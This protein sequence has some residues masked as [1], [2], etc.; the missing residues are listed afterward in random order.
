MK[1]WA[2]APNLFVVLSLASVAVYLAASAAGG[3]LGFPLDDAWI[4][5]T[6]ARN[7]GTLGEFSF[8]PGQL[9]AG[10]TAPL[11]S[12]LIALGYVLRLEPRAWTYALGLVC[13]SLNAWLAYR[14]VQQWWPERRRAARLAGVFV[15]LEWH[16]AWSAV[17]GMETALFAALVLAVFVIPANRAAWLGALVGVSV[18]V[19]PD[20]LTLLPFVLARVWLGRPQGGR[21][22]GSPLRAII[23]CGLGYAAIFV[24]YLLFND[25]L[26]GSFW[27]NTFYAKQAEYA[28]TREAPLLERLGQVGLQPF[29]GAQALLIPGLIGGVVASL[30]QRQWERLIPLAWAA[31]FIGAYLTRLP[32]IYQYGRYVMP[33]IPL[34]V[35]LGVGGLAGLLQLNATHL[36]PRILSRVW[37]AATGALVLTFWGIGAGLYQ[38]DIAIIETEMVATARWINQN[39]PPIALIAAHDIGALGYFGNRRLL[40]MAGLISPEVIPFIRDENRLREWLDASEADYLVTF[41]GWYAGLTSPLTKRF[42]TDGPYSPQ[43]GS[44]NMTVYD[45][46]SA[47]R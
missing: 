40:D 45:W 35:A 42:S 31:A 6:Y 29:I 24:P 25:W 30:R 18:L 46:P 44:E 27:P 11:W 38:R 47:L 28:V 37:L 10:S 8:I 14:L 7:L 15:A 4:H 21:P 2:S 22:Q 13:L 16:L 17:S 39:T 36:W 43:Y 32:V 41:P 1:R 23:N 26:G 33:V 9:S 20:G 34:L 12:A 3:F 5:Q 19:R